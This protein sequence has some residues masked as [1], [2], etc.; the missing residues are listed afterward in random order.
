[1]HV[2]RCPGVFVGDGFRLCCEWADAPV[3]L[4]VFA[5]KDVA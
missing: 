5:L 3:G 1:M 2:A 4:V